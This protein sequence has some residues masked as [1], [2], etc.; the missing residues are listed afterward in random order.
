MS[1]VDAIAIGDLVLVALP[2][3]NPPGREQQGTRPAVV[4]GVPSGE[5]RYPIVAIA[6][7][8]TATGSWSSNNPTLYPLLEAGVGDLYRSSIVLLPQVRGIDVRRVV[9]YLGTLTSEEY[10]PIRE[11]L[12]QL[13]GL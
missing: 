1:E 6:P 5:M 4:V 2:I 10:A 7:L 11:G 12:T 13:F 8:T 3:H 9:R